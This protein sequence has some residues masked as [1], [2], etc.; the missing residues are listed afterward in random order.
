MSRTKHDCTGLKSEGGISSALPYPILTIQQGSYRLTFFYAFTS[1]RFMSYKLKGYFFVFFL[2]LISWTEL[3]HCALTDYLAP[4]AIQF[5]M[6]AHREKLYTVRLLEGEIEGSNRLVVILGEIHARTTQ[7]K[8]AGERILPHF[9]CIGHE[10]MDYS[11]TWGGRCFQW[12]RDATTLSVK[13]TQN[14]TEE[15]TLK[16]LSL[17]M[18]LEQFT[19]AFVQGLEIYLNYAE[20]YPPSQLGKLVLLLQESPSLVANSA[21]IRE[22]SFT[23]IGKPE[24]FNEALKT[25]N[26]S[27]DEILSRKLDRPQLDRLLHNL[28]G[29]KVLNSELQVKLKSLAE[30]FA[31][32]RDASEGELITAGSP[33]NTHTINETKAQS[34]VYIF[35][36]EEGHTPGLI[37]N[38]YSLYLPVGTVIRVGAVGAWFFGNYFPD[39]VRHAFYAAVAVIELPYLLSIGIFGQDQLTPANPDYGF[40]ADRD[41]TMAYN[42]IKTLKQRPQDRTLLGIVGKLHVKGIVNL[43]IKEGFT[44]QVLTFDSGT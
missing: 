11:K 3:G 22:T 37:E 29:N 16:D 30:R 12:C 44:E 40:I 10:C 24:F 32:T 8:E 39:T 17:K 13:I 14:R 4:D 23:L 7:E 5:L 9:L 42:M 25:C 31:K 19:S 20:Q 26:F 43:L 33:T 1:S 28:V 27:Q 41:Q 34:K 38:F 15:S 36:L 6:N 21:N 2:L 35:S 18:K